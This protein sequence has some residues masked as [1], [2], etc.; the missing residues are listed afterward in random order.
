[1]RQRPHPS[2]GERQ[3]Y[4]MYH[5]DSA[6][7]ELDA[8]GKPISKT[9]PKPKAAPQVRTVERVRPPTVVPLPDGTDAVIGAPRAVVSAEE[10]AAPQAGV[11]PSEPP[12]PESPRELFDTPV[13]ADPVP[14]RLLPAPGKVPHARPVH[15]LERH[16]PVGDPCQACARPRTEHVAP[17]APLP[18]LGPT[19]ELTAEEY[20]RIVRI[21]GAHG[22]D[23]CDEPLPAGRAT[24][25]WRVGS[26]VGRTVYG[27]SDEL[28]GVMDTAGLAQT[29]VEAV[30]AHVPA[31]LAAEADAHR[32]PLERLLSAIDDAAAV[33]LDDTL[34]PSVRKAARKLDE[35]L[36]ALFYATKDPAPEPGESKRKRTYTP[37]AL[38][39][40][41]ANA[42][43]MRERRAQLRA[44]RAQTCSP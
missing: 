33:E 19:V 23:D 27:A 1:M 37:E 9:P 39:A 20:R 32:G 22:A 25:P 35:A 10:P 7:P 31:K 15:D 41:R 2:T 40:M 44:E 36:T 5:P 11:G 18:A 14:Y 38:E 24:L 8:K 13:E 34:A 4:C 43:R 42:A 21:T 28:L 16:A 6:P 30:N 26:K 12:T 3:G 17:R 29:V